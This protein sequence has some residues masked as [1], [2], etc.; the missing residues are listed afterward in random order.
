MRR[1][2]EIACDGVGSALAAQAG[3]ADRVELFADL[4]SGGLTPSHATLAV[5]RDRVRLPVFVLIRPRA[6]DFLYRDWEAEVMLRDIQH[7]RALGMDGVVLGALTA[8]GDVDVTLCRELVAAAGDLPV[9]FHRA[10]DAARDLPEALEAVIGL[11]CARV[12]SS[13]GH[14]SAVE[15]A[16]VLADMVQRAA[17]RIGVIAGAGL[18]ASNISDVALRTGCMQLHASAKAIQRSAMQH[19][20]R[21]LTGLALEYAQSDAAQAAALRAALDAL[22]DAH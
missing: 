8:A 20:N 15:G 7:C 12:L 19:H 16:G 3:G 2:L 11:G 1:L 18:T 17:G 6:G 10:F 22:P 9:T 14:G 4:A 21:A 5:T 13:G